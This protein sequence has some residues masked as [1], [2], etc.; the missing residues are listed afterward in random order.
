MRG[1]VDTLPRNSC[2]V[3][4]GMFFSKPGIGRMWIGSDAETHC[5]TKA[6]NAA[7]FASTPGM[8]RKLK[9]GQFR[10]HSRK[11]DASTGKR[12]NLG[13]FAT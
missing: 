1:L 2:I 9:S 3:K 8:I 13:T 11:K 7:G 4:W 10:L 6:T 12:R 5:K